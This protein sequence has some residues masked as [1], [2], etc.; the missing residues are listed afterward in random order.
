M[1]LSGRL[2]AADE[3][4]AYLIRQLNLALRRPGMFGN[5]SALRTLLDHLLFVEERALTLDPGHTRH[6]I[7]RI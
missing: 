2:A 5:E 7:L 4:H 6:W 1:P 3:I